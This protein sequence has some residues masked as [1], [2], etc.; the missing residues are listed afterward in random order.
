MHNRPLFVGA[1][2]GN[3]RIRFGRLCHTCA[4]FA[5]AIAL[6]ALLTSVTIAQNMV[7]PAAEPVAAEMVA[8]PV[9]QSGNVAF[10]SQDLGTIL[11]LS[12]QHRK[13][14]P[15]W[16]GQLRHRLDA[17]H[18]VRRV[19]RVCRWPGDRERH[20]RHRLQRRRR[21][22]HD[23]L[24]IVRDG[25]RP[26]GRHQF[27]GRWNPYQFRQLLPADRRFVRITRRALG[28]PRKRLHPGRQAR[29][30]RSV[31]RNG[32]N[33]LPRKLDLADYTSR[34]RFVV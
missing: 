23:Q 8:P 13:L 28:C 24:S 16:P 19:G 29:S 20:G 32:S 15:R 6:A 9:A 3:Y 21:L 22:P 18:H 2:S 4:R 25:H 1:A 27:V 7:M 10:M 5:V 12:L 17:S 34:G 31:P 14:R 30:G 33:R 11:A 26:H